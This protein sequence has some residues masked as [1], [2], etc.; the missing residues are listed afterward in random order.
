MTRGP[1]ALRRSY[2]RAL[3]WIVENDD[4]EWLAPDDDGQVIP[5]VTASLVADL[6]GHSDEKVARDLQREMKK[7]N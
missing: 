5:S 3:A 4:T 2:R 1:R 6:F 7:R